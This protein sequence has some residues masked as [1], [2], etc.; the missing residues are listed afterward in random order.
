M[1]VVIDDP[2]LG[3]EIALQPDHQVV[4]QGDEVCLLALRPLGFGP[5]LLFQELV[6]LFVKDLLHVPAQLVDESDQTGR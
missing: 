5:R 4:R 6:L 1:A 2:L 3:V